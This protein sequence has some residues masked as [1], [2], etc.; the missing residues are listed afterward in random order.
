MDKKMKDNKG[1]YLDIL[2]KACIHFS[3]AIDT[4]SAI[5]SLNQKTLGLEGWFRIELI[6]ALDG[7]EIIHKVCNKGPDLKLKDNSFLE[8]KAA[9]DLNYEYI[10]KGSNICPC[11]FLGKPRS[12]NSSKVDP[13][14]IERDFKQRSKS[15]IYVNICPLRDDWYLGLISSSQFL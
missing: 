7:T 8:L 4:L 5:E 9:A 10:I 2:G 15:Q 3:R 6:K 14:T 1:L 13:L 12:N 11:L